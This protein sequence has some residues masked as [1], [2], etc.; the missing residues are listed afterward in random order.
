[1]K[2]YRITNVLRFVSK[3]DAP[4]YYHEVTKGFPWSKDFFKNNLK[5]FL[6]EVDENGRDIGYEIFVNAGNT[7]PYLLIFFSEFLKHPEK[8][9]GQIIW[10]KLEQIKGTKA[11]T[12]HSDNAAFFKIEEPKTELAIK[13]QFKMKV[14]LGS[15]HEST[16]TI[17]IDK[18]NSVC[19]KYGISF[20][21]GDVVTILTKDLV[22]FSCICNRLTGDSFY[23][24]PEWMSQFPDK[25]KVTKFGQDNSIIIDCIALFKG[26]RVYKSDLDA[27]VMS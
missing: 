9:I 19:G 21:K 3:Y 14:S 1:M 27:I 6:I 13:G 17:R 12:F 11:H 22:L 25:F 15:R 10:T 2:K 8:L 5:I 7:N 4:D 16:Q 23:I 18:H 26:T 20:Q 24:H